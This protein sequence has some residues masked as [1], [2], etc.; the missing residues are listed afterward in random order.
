L[1]I[2]RGVFGTVGDKVPRKNHLY[3]SFGWPSLRWCGMTTV[4]SIKDED[5]IIALD[6]RIVSQI[7]DCS[8]DVGPGGLF[9]SKTDDTVSR[10]SEGSRTEF[11]DVVRIGGGSRQRAE[12]IVGIAILVDTDC[13]CKNLA[14]GRTDI[15][16]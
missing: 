9:I 11:N 10:H 1:I 7:P 13:E 4:T 16:L 8:D 15:P 6:S 12:E 3:I 2:D 5:R 14:R